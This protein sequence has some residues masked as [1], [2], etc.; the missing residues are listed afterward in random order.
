MKP[1]NRQN[2]NSFPCFINGLGNEFAKTQS[3]TRKVWHTDAHPT[4]CAESQPS[5]FIWEKNT[6]YNNYNGYS[7]YVHTKHLE[8]V[9]AKPFMFN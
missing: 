6:K 8:F 4:Y 2:N 7:G 9:N 5:Y 1:S 3:G